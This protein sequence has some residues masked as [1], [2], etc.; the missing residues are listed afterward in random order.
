MYNRKWRVLIWGVNADNGAG[1]IRWQTVHIPYGV[2]GPNSP[3]RLTVN[4]STDKCSLHE[5]CGQ[6][7]V[8]IDDH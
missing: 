1:A 5:D 7:R 3:L 6:D 4:I 8:T 2:S